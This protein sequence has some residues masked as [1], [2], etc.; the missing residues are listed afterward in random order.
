MPWFLLDVSNDPQAFPAGVYLTALR[1][2]QSSVD[3]CVQAL[4]TEQVA[5]GHATL[6]YYVNDP[7]GHTL[8]TK[9]LM[10]LGLTRQGNL[11][12]ECVKNVNL[13]IHC[14]YS[15]GMH[16]S[17]S[18]SERSDILNSRTH[19]MSLQIEKPCLIDPSW[20]IMYLSDS[21]RQTRQ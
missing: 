19:G 13:I 1:T 7:F 12:V 8:E 10:E 21:S 5:R 15:H 4:L 2:S 18:A 20:T 6:T 9:L 3:Q 11:K 14:G 16:R 17:T